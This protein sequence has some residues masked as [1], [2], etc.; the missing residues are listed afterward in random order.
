MKLDDRVLGLGLIAIGAVI[1]WMARGF[2][3]MAGLPYGPGLFPSIAA[4]GLMVC[5][6][7]IAVTG[8]LA[9]GRGTRTGA[10]R[11][12]PAATGD[13]DVAGTRTAIVSRVFAIIAVLALAALLMPTLGFHITAALSVAATAL[14]FGCGPLLAATL[15]LV[16]AFAAHAIFYTGLR[17]PLPWG[18]LTPW[19]W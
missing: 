13:G 7:I 9:A 5:G 10:G 18:L 6:A 19:A 8:Q 4:I 16:A 14:V 12:A 17:V 15:G 11:P 1:V 3:M 2:P